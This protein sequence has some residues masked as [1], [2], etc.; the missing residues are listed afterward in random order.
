MSLFSVCRQRSDSSQSI[1]FDSD[2]MSL[3]ELHLMEKV[4]NA[5]TPSCEDV[6]LRSID[7]ALE[8]LANIRT[9]KLE[10]PRF[11]GSLVWQPMMPV[12]DLTPVA[13]EP[14]DIPEES[15]D[16]DES[17]QDNSVI[18]MYSLTTPKPAPLSLQVSTLRR[19]PLSQSLTCLNQFA[20]SLSRQNSF[21]SF[22]RV[23][24]S[25]TGARWES[26]ASLANIYNRYIK[27]MVGGRSEYFQRRW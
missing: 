9:G 18:Q 21:T 13:S 20:P 19:T 11:H 7:E 10:A 12:P 16:D 26:Q 17:L 23:P 3:S 6:H 4:K 2:R 24:G 1:N 5:L 22:V 14:A 8:S 15:S 25:V 27:G